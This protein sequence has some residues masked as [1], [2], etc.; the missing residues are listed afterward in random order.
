MK[1]FDHNKS[2]ELA[3]RI[4]YLVIL[5]LILFL[6]SFLCEEVGSCEGYSLSQSVIR[7]GIGKKIQ[8]VLVEFLCFG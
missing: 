7:V 1:N 8:L 3:V 6:V 2:G 5:L 4:S